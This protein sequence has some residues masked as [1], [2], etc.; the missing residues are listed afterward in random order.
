MT[1]KKKTMT[2]LK[3]CEIELKSMK[4]NFNGDRS[5]ILPR[6]QSEDD[7]PA[8]R[9]DNFEGSKVGQV[10]S[11]LI[12]QEGCDKSPHAVEICRVTKCDT[13]I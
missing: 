1:F 12:T 7:S 10:E 3:K 2:R 4:V 5:L 9:Q 13:E 11:T 8:D 6:N